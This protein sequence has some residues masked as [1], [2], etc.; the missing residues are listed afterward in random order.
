MNAVERLK[1]RTLYEY[2]IERFS[3]LLKDNKRYAF[4]RYGWSLFYSLNPEERHELRHDLGWTD[5]SALDFYNT[6]AMACRAGKI[7][8]GLALLEKADKMGLILPELWY[9][10]GLAY[11][12]TG[13]SSKAKA[14]WTKFVEELERR[15]RVPIRYS[16]DLDEI[17]ER[18]KSM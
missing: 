4:E 3:N 17:R 10:L 14:A 1:D 2:E 6:G 9:N 11:E 5:Q 15:V 12:Q 18:L 8:E 13:Q 7:N 16:K